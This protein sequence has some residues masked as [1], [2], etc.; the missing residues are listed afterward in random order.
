M[1]VLSFAQLNKETKLGVS[2]FF[3]F[4]FFFL[5]LLRH[6]VSRLPCMWITVSLGQLQNFILTADVRNIPADST[7]AAAVVQR[8]PWLGL[9]AGPSLFRCAQHS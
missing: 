6:F 1:S 9:T 8:K 5:I 3:D 7:G 4:F 2:D